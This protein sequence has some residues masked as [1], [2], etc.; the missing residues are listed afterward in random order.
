MH[1]R[2]QV[3]AAFFAAALAS[4][5]TA[6]AEPGA[7]GGEGPSCAHHGEGGCPH[8]GPGG[9]CD[10]HRGGSDHPG[11][12]PEKVVRMAEKVGV[13]EAVRKKIATIAF[14][15]RE[16]AITLEADLEKARLDLGRMMHE[17]EADEATVLKQV[18]AVGAAETALKKNR[19]QTMFAIKKLLTDAQRKKLREMMFEKHHGRGGGGHGGPPV[20]APGRK[21]P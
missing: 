5:G 19:I 2:S 9:G 15:A 21:G 14:D 10:H 12:D 18:D 4:G 13:S 11:A 20:H 1:I 17:G 3:F 8:H 7:G 6:L 16:K